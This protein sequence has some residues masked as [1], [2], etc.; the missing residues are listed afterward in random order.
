MM[1]RRSTRT[2]GQRKTRPTG[3]QSSSSTST[4]TTTTSSSSTLLVVL[5]VCHPTSTQWP[6]PSSPQPL[7][8]PQL[9]CLLIVRGRGQP[10]L[11]LLALLQGSLSQL[12][13]STQLPQSS[14]QAAS[15]PLL[16]LQLEQL[17]QLVPLQHSS[18]SLRRPQLLAK[19]PAL[20]VLLLRRDGPPVMALRWYLLWMCSTLPTRRLLCLRSTTG[21]CERYMR[22]F[23]NF[24]KLW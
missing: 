7:L 2:S 4:S 13:P 5:G 11:L 14:S 9:L 21:V 6:L 15:G 18:S 16:A 10:L 12:R 1:V 23:T 3:A 24:Y 19:G 20:L 8:G 22:C 17:H